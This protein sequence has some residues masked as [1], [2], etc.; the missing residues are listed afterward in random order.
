MR[1][2]RYGTAALLVLTLA[3]GAAEIGL[4]GWK[5]FTFREAGQ[6]Q[7]TDGPTDQQFL[8]RQAAPARH[9]IA[10]K[11]RHH[12]TPPQTVKSTANR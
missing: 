4:H 6:G 7:S 12:K 8:S 5:F 11:G 10:P 3:S 9:S 1:I 2:A